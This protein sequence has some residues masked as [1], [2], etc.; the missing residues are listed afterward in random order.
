MASLSDKDKVSAFLHAK[1]GG[2]CLKQ[3]QSVLD[4]DEEQT[5]LFN[6]G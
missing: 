6:V 4:T 2:E 5:T 3:I 1:Y